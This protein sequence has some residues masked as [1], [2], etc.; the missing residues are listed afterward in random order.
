MENGLSDIYRK[1]AA[2]VCA[3]DAVIIEHSGILAH[4]RQVMPGNF[5]VRPGVVVLGNCA[6][7]LKYKKPFPI[8]TF[9]DAV[10]VCRDMRVFFGAEHPG[11]RNPLE[12]RH[13]TE[14]VD[15]IIFQDVATVKNGLRIA[16]IR[17]E[18]RGADL[19][20]VQ[21]LSCLVR[22]VMSFSIPTPHTECDCV[23]FQKSSGF[24]LDGG[25]VSI[26]ALARSATHRR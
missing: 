17:H 5:P 12:A 2:N 13:I 18:R 8:G 23:L 15:N 26:P 9:E 22:A 24:P 10:N 7:R 6:F 25:G 11:F 20:V 1:Q 21:L 19:V 4:L 16:L 14:N 3:A